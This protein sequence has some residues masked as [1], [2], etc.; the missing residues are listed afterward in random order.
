M[1]DPKLARPGNPLDLACAG[2]LCLTGS[3]PGQMRTVFRDYKRFVETYV[4]T[5]KNRYFC[6]ASM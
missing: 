3:W 2:N 1:T 5:Y 4:S 6:P